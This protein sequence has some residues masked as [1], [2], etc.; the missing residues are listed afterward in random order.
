MADADQLRVVSVPCLLTSTERGKDG[1]KR[2]V[3]HARRT[4]GELAEALMP[5]TYPR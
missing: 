2:M 1:V 4:D 3:E 5:K